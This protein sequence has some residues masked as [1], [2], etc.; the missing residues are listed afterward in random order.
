MVSAKKTVRLNTSDAKSKILHLINAGV[1][2]DYYLANRAFSEILRL[3]D[4]AE[5]IYYIT[6]VLHGLMA[7]N[8]SLE[9][10]TGILDACYALDGYDPRK[11]PKL[12]TKNKVVSYVGSGKKGVKT[13]NISS[14]AAFVASCNGASVA[15]YCSPSASS[16]TGSQDFVE[17]IG[18]NIHVPI[19]DMR[20]ILETIGVGY[21]KLEAVVPKF[22]KLYSGIFMAPHALSVALAGMTS[23]FQ[24]D[25]LIYGLA[26]PNVELSLA[27]FE[28]YDVPGV[29]IVNS[30]PD[31]VHYIDELCDAGS[32]TIHGSARRRLSGDASLS[33]ISGSVDDQATLDAIAQLDDPRQNVIKGLQGLSGQNVVLAKQLALNAALLLQESCDMDYKHAYK[34]SLEAINNGEAVG[35][36]L[37]FVELTSGDA[38]KLEALLKEA[39][40]KGAV[41]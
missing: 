25:K 31:E 15:K 11:R 1:P 30:T 16:T 32:A 21:F 4:P 10:V 5:L 12:A 40:T 28:H 23:L 22:A 35:K 14:L 34:K 6:A 27:V 20:S 3:E 18:A 39:R 9:T 24:T 29:T 26:H 13:V 33:S 36:L 19:E 37:Q 8:L 2:V 17:I 7:G 38:S 41:Q